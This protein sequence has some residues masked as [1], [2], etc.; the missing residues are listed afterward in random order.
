MNIFNTQD[1][2]PSHTKSPL[3]PVAANKGCL[4]FFLVKWTTNSTRALDN[5]VVVLA[6]IALTARS[7]LT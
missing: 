1:T 6:Y 2:F 4:S 3:L 7:S 5:L